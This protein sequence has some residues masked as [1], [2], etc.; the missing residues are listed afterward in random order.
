M[1]LS[2]QAIKYISIGVLVV[3]LV[4]IVGA[5]VWDV[6]KIAVGLLLGV[7]L[8]Y[9]GIRYMLG[10]GLPKS[11]ANVVDK[12]MKAGADEEPNEEPNEKPKDKS[13]DK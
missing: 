6:L 1:A 7:G 5:I 13:A 9:L 11:M 10:F 4:L 12:A 3:V 8:I 2:P